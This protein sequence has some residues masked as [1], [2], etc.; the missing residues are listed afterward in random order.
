MIGRQKPPEN[1]AQA[2][3]TFTY[4]WRITRVRPLHARRPSGI[5]RMAAYMSAQGRRCC[6]DIRDRAT[7]QLR[8]YYAIWR[9]EST[10]AHDINSRPRLIMG[11]VN[12]QRSY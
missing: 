4:G 5:R 1:D 7:V 8:N 11:T 3:H 6:H 2:A 9:C 12:D 10:I